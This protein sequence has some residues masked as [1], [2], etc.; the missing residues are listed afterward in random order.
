MSR[1]TAAS[2]VL[3][4]R[5]LT[6]LSEAAEVDGVVTYDF[7]MFAVHFLGGEH[8]HAHAHSGGSRRMNSEETGDRGDRREETGESTVHVEILMEAIDVNSRLLKS[9]FPDFNDR[10]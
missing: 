9:Q 6:V 1:V 3:P 4:R 2:Q 5:Q 7:L 8:A 10:L